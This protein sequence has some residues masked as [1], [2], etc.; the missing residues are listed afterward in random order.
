VNSF[1]AKQLTLKLAGQ[2]DIPF[3]SGFM[4]S[5]YAGDGLT[6]VLVPRSL[7]LYSVHTLPFQRIEVRMQNGT[8]R[9]HG[10]DSNCGRI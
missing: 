1:L 9:V 6:G 5:G 2:P 7:Q 10:N 8:A 3:H 4:I